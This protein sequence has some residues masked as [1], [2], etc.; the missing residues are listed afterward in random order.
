MAHEALQA[1]VGTAI[2]DSTFRRNLLNRS[3]EV[4]RPFGLTPEESAAVE[5]IRAQTIEGFARELH[6]WITRNTTPV[7]RGI[8]Y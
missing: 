5:H 6:G 3:P 4:L 1:I 8:S 2:V 7:V